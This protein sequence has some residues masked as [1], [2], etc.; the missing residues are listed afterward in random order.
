MSY[1]R[2]Y[3]PTFHVEKNTNLIPTQKRTGY[4]PNIDAAMAQINF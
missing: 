4:G 1:G 3:G 2:C